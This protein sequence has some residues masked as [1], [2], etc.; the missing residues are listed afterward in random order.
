M[1]FA[2]RQAP[3]TLTNVATDKYGADRWRVSIVGA[4]SQ[5]KRTDTD[6]SIESGLNARYY[7]NWTTLSNST[8]VFACQPI[9]NVDCAF[10]RGR[11]IVCQAKIKTNA[12]KTIRFGMI[13]LGSGGTVDVLP[14]NVITAQGA[15]STD[16]TLGA[17]LTYSTSSLTNVT[18]GTVSGNALSCSSTTTWTNFAFKVTL[19]TTFKNLVLAIWTDGLFATTDTLSFSE[20]GLFDGD[21]I[22]DWLPELDAVE[23]VKCQ[24]FYQKSQ[25]VD[26]SGVT[27]VADGR[28]Y[29]NSGTNTTNGISVG[30]TFRVSMRIAPTITFIDTAGTAAKVSGVTAAGTVTAGRATVSPTAG[31][32]ALDV[33]FSASTESGIIFAW[34]ADAEI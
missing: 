14:A 15:A 1:R 16:P 3:G 23:L 4:T 24:R 10:L 27:Y 8:K 7:A 11:T 22:R 12:A 25:P 19:G 29:S 9:E 28:Y 13:E 2:Q 18:G 30:L 31:T 21:Q 6:G 34:N 17:N 5:Y 26:T 32:N 20:V 33:T